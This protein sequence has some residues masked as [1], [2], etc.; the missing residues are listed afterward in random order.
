MSNIVYKNFAFSTP[1]L[2][3]Y[4]ELK[5]PIISAEGTPTWP[6]LFPLERIDEL[7]DAVG[8]RYFSAQMMLEF[9]APDRARLDPDA[10]KLYDSE[11]DARNAKIGDHIIT[12]ASIYWDPSTGRKKSD[13]SVCVLIYRDDKNKNIFIHDVL[14]LVISDEELHPLAHQCEMIL[15]FIISHGLRRIYIE[16][17]GIGNAL[18]EIMRSVASARNITVNIQKVTN[19]KNKE[20]RILDA[21]EPILSS[22]RLHAHRRVQS[23]PLIAEMLGWTPMGGSTHDDGL[24]ATAGA[25]CTTPIPIRPLGHGPSTFTANTNFKI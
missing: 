25:I 21:I 5:I 24:D 18:P 13:G 17:N 7:R 3:G 15:D 4:R 10:L 6:E 14:Y 2:R 11:F 19:N 8:A 1:F 16:T 12:G 9:I 23:T 22:G 20:T